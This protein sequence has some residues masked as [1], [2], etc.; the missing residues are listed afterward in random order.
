M[1][2]QVTLQAES[3]AGTG[4]SAAHALKARGRVPG[5]VY[6]HGNALA[7]SL[8]ANAFQHAVKPSHYGAAVVMLVLDGVNSGPVLVKA[9]QRS[10]VGRHVLN[11]ELQ[12]VSATDRLSITVPVALTGETPATRMGGIVEQLTHVIN[13]RCDAMHVP[14]QVI[15]DISAMAMNDSVHAAQLALPVGC[16]LLDKPEE[17]IVRI[18]PPTV[19]VLEEAVEVIAVEPSE[20]GVASE[21]SG[22]KQHD[23][24]SEG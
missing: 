24:S 19:P 22:G 12:R 3:R 23:V 9:V 17:V 5:V 21:V 15:F 2:E 10:P 13:L 6:G 4:K 7:I 1:A 14:E 11:I 20:T 8:D 16:E 18:A